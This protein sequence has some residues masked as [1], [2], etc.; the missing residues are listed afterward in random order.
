MFSLGRFRRLCS[1]YLDKGKAELSSEFDQD[2]DADQDVED[3]ED[4]DRRAVIVRS[5]SAMLD[6]ASV[7]TAK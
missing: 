5:G 6:V 2:S 7:A 1:S 4:L 3:G